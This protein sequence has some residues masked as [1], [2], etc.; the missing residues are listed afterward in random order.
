MMRTIPLT[1]IL[2]FCLPSLI[3]SQESQTGDNTKYTCADTISIGKQQIYVAQWRDDCDAAISYT[4]DD[5]LQEHYTLL[6]AKLR[7]HRF[8]ATFAIV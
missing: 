3:R 1:A 7:E 6:R 4:F 8:P 5:G 2:C